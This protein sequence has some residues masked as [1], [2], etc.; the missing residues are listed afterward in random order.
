MAVAALTLCAFTSFFISSSYAE[1]THRS[2]PRPTVTKSKHPLSALAAP[3]GSFNGTT[4][5]KADATAH[6][7]PKV[8]YPDATV[9][10]VDHTFTLNTNCGQ[11][12]FRSW[13]KKAPATVIAMT[14]LAK[15][16]YFDHTFCHRVTTASIYVL[17]CGDPTAS[18]SGGPMWEY[19]DENLPDEENGDYPAGTVAMANSGANTNG[20]QFFIVYK[21]STLPPNYTIWGT[22]TKGL[23]IVKKVAAQGVVGGG[24][25][26]WPKQNI[27]I[28]S[29]IVK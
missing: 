18:G 28:D 23:D 5:S 8:G 24:T 29:V 15:N 26:G 12:V 27:A 22:I 10:L 11:I 14:F 7:S 20:S 9:A 19:G 2:T 1:T 25:D 13:G 21:D 3:T 16:G 17:Q 6:T 4:C